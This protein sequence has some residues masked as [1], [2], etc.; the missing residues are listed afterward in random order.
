MY[1]QSAYVLARVRNFAAFLWLLINTVY[2]RL[3]T[4]SCGGLTSQ[5]SIT[6]GDPFSVFSAMAGLVAIGTKIC[7]ELSQFINNVRCAPSGIQNLAHQLQELC[8]ILGSLERTFRNGVCHEELSSDLRAVLD[9]CMEKFLQ[10]GVIVQRYGV[11]SG[12]GRLV[13][14]WKRCMWAFQEKEVVALGNQFEA[15]K[16]TLNITLLLS[17][18]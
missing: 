4:S 3:N 1:G 5:H 9:S 12:D 17:A 10:L 13:Q 16:T 15:H 7:V 8:S 2:S 11:K 6:M 14:L 18:W